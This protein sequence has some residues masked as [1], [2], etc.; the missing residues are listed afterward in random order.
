MANELI[1]IL[2]GL[3]LANEQAQILA[4]KGCMQ[5]LAARLQR[6]PEFVQ[7]AEALP[8]G[9]AVC[10]ATP[11]ASELNVADRAYFHQTMQSHETILADVVIGRILH[12]PV[13]IFGKAIRDADQNPTGALF[14]MLGLNWLKAELARVRLPNDARLTVLDSA[15]AVVARYPDPE[16]W[17]GKPTEQLPI[18][19]Q[20]LRTGG[21][22]AVE[23]VNLSGEQRLFAYAPLFTTFSGSNYTLWLSMPKRIIEAPARRDAVFGLSIMVLVLLVTI[24]CVLAGTDRLLL[25]PILKLSQTAALLKAGNLRARSGLAH[26]DDELGRLAETLDQTAAVIEDRERRLRIASDEMRIARD[27][28]EQ[29]SEAKSAFLNLVSHELRTPLAQ[30]ELQLELHRRMF[31]DGFSDRQNDG[32]NGVAASITRLS[33]LINSVLEYSRIH[34]GG[35]AVHSERFDIIELVAEACADVEQEARRRGLEVTFRC[36]DSAI[37]LL[38]DPALVMLIVR[39]LLDNAIKYTLTAAFQ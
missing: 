31:R 9:D 12:G 16:A 34:G 17:I 25:Q 29:A 13:I 4:G 24:A 19:E 6:E 23:G 27:R 35:I 3:M 21:S 11:F 2:N 26:G 14:V 8:D 33:R 20:A 1:S 15:G 36:D 30:L 5:F 32:L 7:I 22:G 39:N 10:A 18:V 28:A 37:A 38:S